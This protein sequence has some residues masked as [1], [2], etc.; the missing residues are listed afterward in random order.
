MQ[1]AAPAKPAAPAPPAKPA[2]PA[3]PAKPAAPAP[4]AKPAPPAPVA[5]AEPAPPSDDEP[6]TDPF[7]RTSRSPPGPISQ[8]PP[9]MARDRPSLFDPSTSPSIEATF[10]KLL[11]DVDASFDDLIALGSRPPPGEGETHESELQDVRALF[12]QLAAKHVRPVRDFMID[13]KWGEAASTW[14]AVSE[15]AV[16]SL[17]GAADRLTLPELAEALDGYAHALKAAAVA[18]LPTVLG[19]ARDMLLKA[20]ERLEE[21]M[22]AAFAL[23]VDHTQRESVIVHSLLL[24]VPG[25]RKATIDKL[26]AAG[27]SSLE[28]MFAAKPDEIAATT[29]VDIKLCE[30]IVERFQI[31]KSELKSS[32]PDATRAAERD[33]L[34][35]LVKRLRYQHDEFEKASSEWSADAATKKKATREGRA[36]TLL[37]VNVVLARLGEVDRLKALE[38]MAF[39]RKVE[40]LERFLE[41]AEKTF[42]R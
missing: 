18:P 15:P 39:G 22:P 5:H 41:E 17:R 13:L 8:R 40:D 33:R 42:A 9:T 7:V 38:R 1:H 4:P 23:D 3:P 21:A 37:E 6:P 11:S 25:V 36:A 28:P 24:Q 32:V 14:L 10:D 16:R 19:D 27:L 12:A 2:A 34:A 26:Y 30:R 29:G 31:Y 35:Q 20:Y